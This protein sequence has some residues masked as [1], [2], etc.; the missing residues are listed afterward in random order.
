MPD[1]QW[2]ALAKEYQGFH[3]WGFSGAHD[4]WPSK[5]SATLVAQAA[6]KSRRIV[7]EWRKDPIYRRGLLWLVVADYSRRRPGKNDDDTRRLLRKEDRAILLHFYVK[8]HWAG[9]V[10]SPI[11]VDGE[12]KTFDT[13]DAYVDHLLENDVIPY[14]D[15]KRRYWNQK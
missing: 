12:P 6:G 8:K 4:P 1:Y 5:T 15:A 9:P 7:Y 10:S 14:E 3:D 13:I 11:D 2:A